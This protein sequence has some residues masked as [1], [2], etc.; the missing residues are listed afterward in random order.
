M[1]AGSVLDFATQCERNKEADSSVHCHTDTSADSAQTGGL[2]IVLND[3]TVAFLPNLVA[4]V[5]KEVAELAAEA[6][7]NGATGEAVANDGR[8]AVQ[9]PNLCVLVLLTC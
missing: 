9:K 6:A 7:S 1:Q 8:T 5:E 3:G 2:R 4:I